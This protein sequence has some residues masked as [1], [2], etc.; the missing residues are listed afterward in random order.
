[1]A[2]D[3]ACVLVLGIHRC[4]AVPTGPLLS[5][6]VMAVIGSTGTWQYFISNNG[7]EQ[8]LFAWLFLR[9]V[10]VDFFFL[11]YNTR[12]H[13]KNNIHRY[14]CSFPIYFC[15]R[16]NKFGFS[17]CYA[18]KKIVTHNYYQLPRG[19]LCVSAEFILHLLNVFQKRGVI[20]SDPSCIDTIWLWIVTSTNAILILLLSFISRNLPTTCTPPYTLRQCQSLDTQKNQLF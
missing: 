6:R 17:F 11:I 3:V 12:L 20:T 13:F 19:Y 1:M 4:T 16:P 7:C 14:H 2:G 5:S 15:I 8:M 18:G 10:L 9:E